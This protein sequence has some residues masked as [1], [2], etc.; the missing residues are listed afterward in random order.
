MP[1]VDG[2]EFWAFYEAA[3]QVGG[4][5]YDFLT[6]PNGKQAAL[7]ADVSGK[8]VP[9]ALL[10]ARFSSDVKVSLITHPDD[11]SSAVVSLN[12]ILCEAMLDDRFVTMLVA[13]LD[14]ASG[15]VQVVN[16]GHMAPMVRRK[17]GQ[18]EEPAGDEGTA[19]LPLGIL[20]DAT[21]PHTE[22]TLAPGELAVVYSDGINEAMNMSDQ[23]FSAD[24]LRKVIGKPPASAKQVGE[25]LI[26][27]V[28]SF[29]A[30]R[31][32]HD[33]M[34]LVVFSRSR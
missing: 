13:V 17:E 26:R 1:K 18:V 4:D 19:S 25:A 15:V 6:L 22:F 29:S 28:K 31:S 3:G 27:D 5:Y 32:Q 21:Y 2:Y 20:P 34:T 10:M 11:L 8:G 9:A 16:A 14:P 23:Q 30:G 24:R 12:R 7:V 33:D